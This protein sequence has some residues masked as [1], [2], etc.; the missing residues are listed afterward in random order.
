MPKTRRAGRK[1]QFR[2]I[3]T[4]YYRPATEEYSS[5]FGVEYTYDSEYEKLFE[6]N[7]N[8]CDKNNNE[9]TPWK[10]VPI[11]F[12]HRRLPPLT[13][14]GRPTT[15]TVY[16]STYRTVEEHIKDKLS[17]AIHLYK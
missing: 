3:N 6:S 11:T 10:V 8:A 15:T 2:R 17:R 12:E 4:Q 5:L 14:R 13:I 16:G 1:N 7:P 9:A